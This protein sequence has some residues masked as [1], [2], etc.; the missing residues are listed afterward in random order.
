[1]IAGTGG[2][3]LAFERV[4]TASGGTDERNW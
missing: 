3:A 4:T 1:M 2:A